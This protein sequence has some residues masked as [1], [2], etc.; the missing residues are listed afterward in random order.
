M[1]FLTNQL[2]NQMYTEMFTK[3]IASNVLRRHGNVQNNLIIFYYIRKRTIYKV[4]CTYK[5]QLER[6]IRYFFLEINNERE[7][8][9]LN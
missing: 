6:N 5:K 7:L 1:I 4:L 3:Y 8:Y 2:Y 9:G